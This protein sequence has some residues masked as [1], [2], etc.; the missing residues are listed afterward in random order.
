MVV[1]AEGME[2]SFL[3]PE[4][5]QGMF[6]P[7]PFT[8]TVLLVITVWDL[9]CRLG[10]SRGQ[11]MGGQDPLVQTDPPTPKARLVPENLEGR[12]KGR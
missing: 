1:R 10:T 5:P 3:L 8:S 2:N 6:A 7:L 4:L 9:P 12:G 11:R